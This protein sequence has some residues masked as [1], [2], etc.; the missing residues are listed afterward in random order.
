MA[1]E[2]TSMQLAVTS[3]SGAAPVALAVKKVELYDE[4]GTLL[5]ELAS[6]LPTVWVSDK[7]SY[8]PWDQQVAAGAQLSVSYLLAPPNWAAIGGRRDTMYSVKAIVTVGGTDQTLTHD[9]HVMGYT[10]LPP[11][12]RT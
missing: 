6:R 10:T 9:V 8:Q 5:G 2:Q 11:N 12:V 4:N 3:P 7:G 1:C